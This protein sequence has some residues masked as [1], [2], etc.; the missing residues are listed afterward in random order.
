MYLDSGQPHRDAWKRWPA[1]RPAI[2]GAVAVGALTAST[3]GSASNPVA[4]DTGIGPGA[5][6]SLPETA[7]ST[8]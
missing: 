6:Q 7:G 3:S 5:G 8:Q 4:R 2:V 1:L